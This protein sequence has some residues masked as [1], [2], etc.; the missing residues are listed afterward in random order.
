MKDESVTIQCAH[1]NA[2]ANPFAN[3]ELEGEAVVSEM[4]LQWSYWEWIFQSC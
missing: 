2:M 3:V 4:L 1:G